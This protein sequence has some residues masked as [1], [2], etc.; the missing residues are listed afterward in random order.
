MKYQTIFTVLCAAIALLCL[1]AAKSDDVFTRAAKTAKIENG[2]RQISYEQFLKIRN[3]GEKYV[4]FDVLAKDS[5]ESGHIPGSKSFPLTDIDKES[6]KARLSKNDHV[7]VYCGSFGCTASTAAAKELKKLGYNVLDYKGGLKEW[8]EK[9][10]KL[11]K[12]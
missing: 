3:S 9:G 1:T 2:T 4:L 11:V 6:A 8:Q 5:Y 7:I 10:N 12:E